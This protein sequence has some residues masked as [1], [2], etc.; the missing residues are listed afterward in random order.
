MP[1][2]GKQTKES[3]YNA[4]L[5]VKQMK[6][7]NRDSVLREYVERSW[8]LSPLQPKRLH[9]EQPLSWAT[10]QAKVCH[11]VRELEHPSPSQTP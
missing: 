7:D 8:I 9:L 11:S 4:E 10:T 5:N 2:T 1:L 6:S 3:V